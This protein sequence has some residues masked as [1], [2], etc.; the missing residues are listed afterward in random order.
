MAQTAAGNALNDAR[1][2]RQSGQVEAAI[3][4]VGAVLAA[5]PRHAGAHHL[6]GLLC[7]DAGDAVSAITHFERS[8]SAHPDALEVWNDLGVA[9]LAIGSPTDAARS[10]TGALALRPRDTAALRGLARAQLE[11]G[12]RDEA[13]ASFQHALR[14]LPYDKYAAHMVAALSGSTPGASSAYVADLFDTYADQFDDHLTGALQYR[15]PAIIAERVAPYPL[16]SLLDLGCGTG[17]VGAALHPR[18]AVMDGIDI[19]PQMVRRARDRGIYRH[20]RSGELAATLET[21]PAL[22]GPYD[23]ITA[24]DVFVYLGNLEPAFAAIARVASPGSLIAFS[25]ET[26]SADDITLRANGRFAHSPAYVARLMDE[27]GFAVLEK[28]DLPI[29]QERNRPVPGSLYLLKRA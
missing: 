8:L 12:Q 9:Q 18:I 10:F 23:L 28:L 1:R 3:K 2:L 27:R 29:R 25:V 21:D 13:L 4:A 14:I 19:A 11:L 17:L 20:L 6:M 15:L 22:S 5:E 7:M 24:A 26:S 16:T